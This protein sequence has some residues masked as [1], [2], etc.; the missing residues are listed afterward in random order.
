M[1]FLQISILMPKLTSVRKDV[2]D[3]PLAH[4]HELIRPVELE[5]FKFMTFARENF[6]SPVG[7]SNIKVGRKEASLDARVSYSS[8][9]IP[10]PLLLHSST[11]LDALAME[12]FSRI[13]SFSQLVQPAAGAVDRRG[14]KEKEKEKKKKGAKSEPASERQAWLETCAQRIA[15]IGMMR[16]S[17]FPLDFD[18]FFSLSHSWFRPLQSLSS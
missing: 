16:T 7:F 18:I 15:E 9:R 12:S 2:E 13:L 8:S 6:R 1:N 4:L 10:S 17:V 3:V 11:E 14:K 5:A